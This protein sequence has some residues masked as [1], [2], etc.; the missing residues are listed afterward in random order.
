MCF[1]LN[2]FYVKGVLFC[3]CC[4]IVG[5]GTDWSFGFVRLD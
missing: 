3:I 4:E 2:C 1:G 5:K